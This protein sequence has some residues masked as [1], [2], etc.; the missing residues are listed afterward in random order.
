MKKRESS[1]I[2]TIITITRKTSVCFLI[3]RAFV[4]C[5]ANFTLVHAPARIII[6]RI[7]TR[8]PLIVI[9]RF[10]SPAHNEIAP[11]AKSLGGSRRTVS[12]SQRLAAGHRHD[13]LKNTQSTAVAITI[14]HLNIRFS[15]IDKKT[16]GGMRTTRIRLE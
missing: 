8:H 7:F 3:R 10:R 11:L 16:S 2:I 1:K 5:T 9:S 13:S 4:L 6:V 15:T 14:K 12:R